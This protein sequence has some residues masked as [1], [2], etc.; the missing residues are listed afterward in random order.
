MH[1]FVAISHNMINF[2]TNSTSLANGES[3]MMKHLCYEYSIEYEPAY[4]ITSE[5]SERSSY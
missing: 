1:D 5:R 2:L 4:V 3:N